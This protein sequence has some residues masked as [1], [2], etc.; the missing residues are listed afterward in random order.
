MSDVIPEEFLDIF[1]KKAFANLA[2][3]LPNGSP[4]VTPV[5]CD[6]DGEY[7]MVNTALGRQKDRNMRRNPRVALSLLDPDNPYRYL[8]VRGRVAGIT[9]EGAD[10]HIDNLAKKYMGLDEYPY[11]RPGEKRVIF[12]IKPEHT[13]SMG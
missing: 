2:T 6:Y 8:E 5:W 11:R 3:L 4:Q 13:T 12:K 7:V 1:E 9:E 10:Q